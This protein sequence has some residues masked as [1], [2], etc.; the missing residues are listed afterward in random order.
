M[1]ASKSKF[2]H[3]SNFNLTLYTEYTMNIQ[4]HLWHGHIQ[5]CTYTSVLSQFRL[6]FCDGDFVHSCE[7]VKNL[8]ARITATLIYRQLGKNLLMKS[9][10]IF[11][12]MQLANEEIQHTTSLTNCTSDWTAFCAQMFFTVEPTHEVTINT[13]Y[14]NMRATFRPIYRSSSGAYD[15]FT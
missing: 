4:Y 12:W 9:I 3:S 10:S 14:N 1:R 5:W 7:R 11:N 8:D 13:W 6:S 15:K 2:L